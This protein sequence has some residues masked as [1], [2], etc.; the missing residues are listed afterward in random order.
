MQC[1]VDVSKLLRYFRYFGYLENLQDLITTI[2]AKN[3]MEKK[4][5][6]ALLVGSSKCG[7]TTFMKSWLRQ[8]RPNTNHYH[9]TAA[10]SFPYIRSVSD[11]DTHLIV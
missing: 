10:N 5:Y 1:Y 3:K 11:D 2:P 8:A 7:K 9:P 4:I 6:C